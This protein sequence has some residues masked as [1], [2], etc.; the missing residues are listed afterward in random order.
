MNTNKGFGMDKSRNFKDA[1]KAILTYM[2][3]VNMFN[4]LNETL[5]GEY[6]AYSN[7]LK[8]PEGGTTVG[9]VYTG[10]AAGNGIRK[11]L[12]TIGFKYSTNMKKGS[13][14]DEESEI[15]IDKTDEKRMSTMIKTI[16]QLQSNVRYEIDTKNENMAKNP[17]W[18][19]IR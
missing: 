13:G 14:I 12:D 3:A 16:G 8:R 4:K 2:D 18:Q 11:I 15:L 7:K 10:F 9:F 5:R 6:Y 1:N 17:L 19:Q